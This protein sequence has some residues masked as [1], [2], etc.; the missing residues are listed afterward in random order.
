[1][2]KRIFVDMDGVLAEFNDSATFN[3]LHTKGYF[4]N[5]N[6]QENIVDAVK[7]LTKSYEVFIISCV[8]KDNPHA[9]SEKN[10]WLDKHLPEVS[11]S[12]RIFPTCGETKILHIP[13]FSPETDILIDDYSKNCYEWLSNGGTYVKVSRCILDAITE[14]FRHKFTISPD[15]KPSSISAFINNVFEIMEI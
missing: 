3:D 10:A 5:L 8:L 13:E 9:K 6:P 2:K 4:M 12:H 14:S 7:L 15:E 1:M 11:R